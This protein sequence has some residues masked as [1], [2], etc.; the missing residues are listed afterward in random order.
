M[1]KKRPII[2]AIDF[3]NTLAI[4]KWP[5]IVAPNEKVVEFVRRVMARGDQWI[6]WTNRDGDNLKAAL[7]WCKS[8]GIYPDA[9]NDNLPQMLEFFG[10]NPRKI[11]ANYYIDDR[12]AGGLQL[13]EEEE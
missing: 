9:T 1:E 13:P 11:F 4:T 5:A 8:Q 3:D 10:G 12:N 2:Y 7:A 6:L